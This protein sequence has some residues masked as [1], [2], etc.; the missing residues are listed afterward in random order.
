[1]H[2]RLVHVRKQNND[3]RGGRFRA[4]NN[5]LQGRNS[6]LEIVRRYGN[7]GRESNDCDESME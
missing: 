7:E 4:E 3:V 6:G 5:D 1:M 2:G